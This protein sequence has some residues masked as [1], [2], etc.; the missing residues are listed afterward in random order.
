VRTETYKLI[1]K[2]VCS[3]PA[4]ALEPGQ[5]MIHRNAV[6]HV[7]GSKEALNKISMKLL[8]LPVDAISLK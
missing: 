2:R 8:N 7:T 4:A 3:S 1:V 5:T 6:I